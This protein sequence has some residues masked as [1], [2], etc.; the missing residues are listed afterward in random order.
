MIL[1][2][3]ELLLGAAKLDT[4]N[5]MSFCC[6][7]HDQGNM[8][9]KLI[10]RE[11]IWACYVIKALW[12]TLRHLGFLLWKM[13]LALLISVCLPDW[14]R[15][16]P[17]MW[18]GTLSLNMTLFWVM[19]SSWI[20]IAK[21]WVTRKHLLALPSL[22]HV[23]PAF[24]WREKSHSVGW[25]KQDSSVHLETDRCFE[26]SEWRRRR[27]FRLLIILSDFREKLRGGRD[28]PKVTLPSL[29]RK[30]RICIYIYS[31]FSIV[32]ESGSRN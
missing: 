21:S 13:W 16:F 10:R 23:S 1:L 32:I 30:V 2:F 6:C 27:N 19:L 9:T 12:I 14:K 7:C 24:V 31:D 17:G 5:W 15:M 18:R 20:T 25:R 29:G 8:I 26:T 4:A 22:E 3:V 28:F 11:M